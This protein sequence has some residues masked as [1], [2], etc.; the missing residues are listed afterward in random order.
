MPD[1]RTG[2]T[3]RLQ[4]DELDKIT[5]GS[6]REESMQLAINIV[7]SKLRM[8][9]AVMSQITWATEPNTPLRFDTLTLTYAI[10]E[11]LIWLDGERERAEAEP[12]EKLRLDETPY[13]PA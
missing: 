7:L 6:A 5:D 9:A 12:A 3:K 2:T 13:S 11:T 10:E 4:M 8:F 1:T